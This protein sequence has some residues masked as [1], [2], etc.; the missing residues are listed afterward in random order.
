VPTNPQ[1]WA[2]GFVFETLELYFRF[3]NVRLLVLFLKTNI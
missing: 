2:F 1:G 3:G